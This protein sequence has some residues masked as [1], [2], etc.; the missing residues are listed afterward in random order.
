MAVRRQRRNAGPGAGECGGKSGACPCGGSSKESCTCKGK[1]GPK[2]AAKV[3]RV[4]KGAKRQ[5]ADACPLPEPRKSK[6]PVVKEVPRLHRTAEPKP[7]EEYGMDYWKTLVTRVIRRRYRV[8]A[9]GST[10]AR[11]D[12]SSQAT[13]LGKGLDPQTGTLFIRITADPTETSASVAVFWNLPDGTSP[14]PYLTQSLNINEV[15]EVRLW[16]GPVPGSVYYVLTLTNLSPGSKDFRIVADVVAKRRGSNF[17][18]GMCLNIQDP[19][20]MGVGV[21]PHEFEEPQT[22]PRKPAS[23]RCG[24]RVKRR[25]TLSGAGDRFARRN[26][27]EFEQEP[28]QELQEGTPDSTRVGGTARYQNYSFGGQMDYTLQSIPRQS[29]TTRGPTCTPEASAV[30]WWEARRGQP[31]HCAVPDPEVEAYVASPDFAGI[32]AADGMSFSFR[33]NGLSVN[34]DFPGSFPTSSAAGLPL[35]ETL[36]RCVGFDEVWEEVTQGLDAERLPRWTLRDLLEWVPGIQ[37]ATAWR[38]RLTEMFRTSGGGRTSQESERDIWSY[39]LSPEFWHTSDWQWGRTAVWLNDDY[40]EMWFIASLMNLVHAT[41]DLLP[42]VIKTTRN[43]RNIVGKFEDFGVWLSRLITGNIKWS[44]GSCGQSDRSFWDGCKRRRIRAHQ[45]AWRMGGAGPAYLKVLPG[46]ADETRGNFTE[47]DLASMSWPGEWLNDWDRNTYGDWPSGKTVGFPPPIP[48][49]LRMNAHAWMPYSD[50][51]GKLFAAARLAA[52]ACVQLRSDNIDDR[53]L[54]EGAKRLYRAYLGT[55]A[56]PGKTFVHEL[57]HTSRGMPVTDSGYAGYLLWAVRAKRQT[58]CRT[59]CGQEKMGT[60]WYGALGKHHGIFPITQ[61]GAL[62]DHPTV[63]DQSGDA[64]DIGYF[65]SECKAGRLGVFT[66]YSAWPQHIGGRLT[67][68]WSG[69]QDAGFREA[70]MAAGEQNARIK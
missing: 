37:G 41:I 5:K 51:A 7:P 45:A 54:L 68:T 10:S 25:P 9:G 32:I 52:M 28:R 11:H 53:T 47:F 58:H 17:S 1:E 55:L 59:G 60:Y 66:G 20:L 56:V 46:H 36:G 2:G 24:K 57:F 31:T 3:A 16:S 30:D 33:N 39:G 18:L 50:A 62:V 4:A 35:T 34:V 64:L 19:P 43:K 12:L 67:V 48:A 29:C 6:P 65:G 21:G 27:G 63:F 8:G 49:T 69:A 13:M 38:G 15:N 40:Q 61:G 26:P 14:Y 42:K 70:C 44:P 23:S 22:T